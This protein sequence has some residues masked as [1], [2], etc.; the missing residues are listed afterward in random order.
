MAYSPPSPSPSEAS[1]SGASPSSR[2]WNLAG[3]RSLFFLGLHR[4]RSD[5]RCNREVIV[6]VRRHNA[7][8]QADVADVERIADLEAIQPNVDLVRDIRCVADELQL[9]N[10]DV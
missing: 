1:P 4:R 3:R 6:L 10:D 8:W 9:V 2:G 5:N 7:V